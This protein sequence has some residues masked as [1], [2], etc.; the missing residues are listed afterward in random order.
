MNEFINY[1]YCKYLSILGCS[2]VNLTVFKLN[3]INSER[4]WMALVNFLTSH[5]ETKK[6]L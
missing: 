3:R 5:F 6:A 2:V 1:L 4:R